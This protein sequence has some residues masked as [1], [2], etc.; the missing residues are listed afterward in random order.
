ML[1]KFWSLGYFYCRYFILC[2]NSIMVALWWLL[3]VYCRGNGNVKVWR[4]YYK[5]LFLSC[6][7]LEFI[8]LV[9]SEL[10]VGLN[11]CL[12]LSVINRVG[13]SNEWKL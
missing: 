13:E 2:R 11:T 6:Q 12:I 8:L 10:G 9:H 3:N 7:V 4:S 5:I 1:I